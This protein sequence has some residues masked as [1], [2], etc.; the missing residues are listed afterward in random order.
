MIS[1]M[2]FH[3]DAG[4]HCVMLQCMA[5]FTAAACVSTFKKIPVS[6]LFIVMQ[7]NIK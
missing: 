2:C 3:V 6:D 7:N 4:N 1:D 5:N